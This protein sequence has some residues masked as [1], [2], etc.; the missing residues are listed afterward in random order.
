MFDILKKKDHLLLFLITESFVFTVGLFH[1]PFWGDFV[2]VC[3]TRHLK[4]IMELVIPLFSDILWMI[5]EISKVIHL[6]L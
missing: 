4:L 3:K 1:F 2:K 5:H 6:T